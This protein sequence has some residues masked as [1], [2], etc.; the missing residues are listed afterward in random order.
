[1][2]SLV[3]AVLMLAA[4]A[5]GKAEKKPAPDD[6]DAPTIIHIPITQALPQQEL[7]IEAEIRDPSGVFEPSVSWRPVGDPSWRVVKLAPTGEKDKF[8]AALSPSDVTAD[9]EYFIEAYDAQ[10]NGPARMGNPG[11]PMQV[12]VKAAKLI[13]AAAPPKAP[14]PAAPVS[15][16]PAAVAPAPAPVE[17][18]LPIAPLATMGAGGLALVVGATLW[19][20]ASGDASDLMAK[21]PGNIPLKPEDKDVAA[22][23]QT[24]GQIGSILMIAGVAIAGGG[25][26]WYFVSLAPAKG[27]ALQL[28][29]SF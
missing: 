18:G 7:R 13:V 21:Y 28:T 6:Q 12:K 23:V 2:T 14:E 1:M 9:L 20:M 16:P 26:A 29:V 4:P 11:Q 24:R 10:G 15:A 8:R 17:A 22:G 25:A 3:L 27:P 5:K 19:F